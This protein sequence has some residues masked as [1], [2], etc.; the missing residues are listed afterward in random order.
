MDL[1]TNEIKGALVEKHM[2][3]IKKCV[4]RNYVKT[5]L[6]T[7]TVTLISVKGDPSL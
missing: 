7:M 4:E 1:L 3:G 6:V 5:L 2:R